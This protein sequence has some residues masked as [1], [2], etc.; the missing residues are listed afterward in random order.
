MLRLNRSMKRME[1]EKHQLVQVKGE[2][3]PGCSMLLRRV[4]LLFHETMRVIAIAPL[5]FALG[6]YARRS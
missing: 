6:R 5:G 4:H 3:S 1:E 2:W